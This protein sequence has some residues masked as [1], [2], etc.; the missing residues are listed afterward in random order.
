MLLESLGMTFNNAGERDESLYIASLEPNSGKLVVT[1]GVM[2]VLSR[3]VERL[4]V[5]RSISPIWK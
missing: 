5:F 3:R 4:G 2:E 1:L